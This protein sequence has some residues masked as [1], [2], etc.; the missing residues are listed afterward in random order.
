MFRAGEYAEK[1]TKH[2]LEPPLRLLRLKHRN[3][4]LFADDKPQ[5]G[6]EIG[7]QPAV[8]AQCLV[9]GLAPTRQLGVALAKKGAHQALKSLHQRRIGNVAL[10]LVELACGEQP[11][12]GTRALCSSLTTEDL[13]MPE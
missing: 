5:F 12:G 8:R 4:R 11:A 7:N 2:E 13:P 9:K 6:D 1:A 3:R 10:V